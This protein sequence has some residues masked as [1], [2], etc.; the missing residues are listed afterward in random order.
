MDWQKVTGYVGLT[1]LIISSLAQIIAGILPDYRNTGPIAE[2][3]RWSLFLWA[4][5]SIVMGLY[6]MRL[7]GQLVECVWGAVA[8]AFCL[9]SLFGMFAGL[10]YFFRS[11]TKLSKLKDGLPF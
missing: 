7:N 8:A 2:F 10:V 5:A 6:L 3:I 11:Y 4:Y 9:V 1:C